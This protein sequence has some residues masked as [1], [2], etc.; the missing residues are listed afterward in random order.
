[1]SRRQIAQVLVH[2]LG[3]EAALNKTLELVAERGPASGD[4]DRLFGAL[5]ADRPGALDAVLDE[6][7]M[8]LAAEPARVQ[9]DLEAEIRRAGTYAA[10]H[11]DEGRDPGPRPS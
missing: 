1:M 3:S 9:A 6:P 4:L 8:P 5:R 11:A 2:S 7:N 10:A